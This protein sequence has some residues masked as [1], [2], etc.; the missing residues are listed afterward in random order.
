MTGV[1]YILSID[2]LLTDE[3]RL[4]WQAARDFGVK[5]IAPV[6]EQHYERGTFPRELIPEF[7]AMGF[8]G[9]PLH[10][11]G[12][13]GMNPVAYGLT[14]IELERQDSGIRSFCSVQ[15]ALA[16][17]PIFAYGDEAQRERWLPGMARG[18]II[19]AFGLTEPNSGSDPGSMRTHARQHE[20]GG[21]YVLTGQ[22]MWIT[23][24]PIADVLVVWAKTLDFGSDTP[25]IR[26][27]LVERGMAGLQTPETHGKLSLRASITGEI[28]L[29]EVRVPA[30]NLLPGVR[31][32]KGPLGCL[33]QARYGIGWGAVGAA[34]SVYERARDYTLQRTQFGRPIAGFQL[35]Q[36]KLVEL[37]NDIGKGLL[38]A[39][40]FGRLKQDGKLTPEQV[41]YLKRDNV[42]M[43]LESARTARSM[44][45][46]N[47]IMGE[48]HIMRHLCNLETVY[49]YEGTH[50]IH[51]LAIGRA[52]TGLSAFD[53]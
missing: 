32:L 17:W 22:K 40:H 20:A 19:G 38:L 37:H 31:G 11:Y 28:V 52:L 30:K 25:V 15:S 45:G 39:Y 43:A 8:L 35:T 21:D 3:E 51:T 29:D 6:I 18:E 33:T 4:T 10:G 48:F 44:L 36:Q 13:A 27:F 26:G 46:G 42:R 12:C 1:P 9:A 23:N 53:S 14:M 41:S 49:T 16:M 34:M 24:S 47:G 50:E 7:A 5:R 2:H